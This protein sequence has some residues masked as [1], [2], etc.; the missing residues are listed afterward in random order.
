M[1]RDRGADRG[2]CVSRGAIVRLATLATI[3]GASF[4]LIKLGLEGLSPVQLV[5]G[6]MVTGTAVLG[7]AAAARRVPLPR[8]PRLWGHLAFMGVVANIVPFTLFGYGE[9][10]ISSGLAGVLNGTTPLFTLLVAVLAARV[11]WT[12]EHLTRRRV[13][14]LLVG[15]AGVVVVVAPWRGGLEGA[16]DGT[17]ACLAAA[18][19]YGVGF[20]YTRR[21][22]TPSGYPALALS[23][24]QLSCGTALLLL[25]APLVARGP[26]DL[27]G[28]VV[29]ATLVLGGLGT[30]LAYLLY[31]RLVREAGATGA[32]MVTYL[33]PVVAVVLGVLVLDEPLT[34]ELFAGAGVV[35]AGVAYAED[36][37]GGGSDPGDPSRGRRRAPILTQPH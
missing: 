31:Y 23:V 30:G 7:A 12:D 29:A 25:A 33:I 5:I 2:R 24:G 22:V 9:Q 4:L 21:F 6:R 14:G 3:W 19:S 36:R 16:L 35:I 27:S 11:G 20:V 10:R 32:S 34:W 13:I 17:L 37:L 18:A 15:F 8:D 28:T 1:G 26:V